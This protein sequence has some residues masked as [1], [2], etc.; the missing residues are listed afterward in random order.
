MTSG[1]QAATSRGRRVRLGAVADLHCAQSSRGQIQPVPGQLAELVD[2]LLL[3]GDLT[4]TGLPEEA[5]VLARELSGAKA[6]LVA[7]LGNHDYESGKP[8]E[9]KQILT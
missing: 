9:V 7:V 5:H 6:P 4:D 8:E 3:G 2:V 1:E